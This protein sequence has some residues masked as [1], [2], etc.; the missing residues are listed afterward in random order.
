MTQVESVKKSLMAAVP[1]FELA[2][3]WQVIRN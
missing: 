2:T 1:L 3:Q